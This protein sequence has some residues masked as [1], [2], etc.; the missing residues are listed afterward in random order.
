MTFLKQVFGYTDKPVDPRSIPLPLLQ[1]YEEWLKEN[2]N[3]YE[4]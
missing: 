2:P 1:T 3:G 4:C